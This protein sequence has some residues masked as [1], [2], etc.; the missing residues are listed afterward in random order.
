[1]KYEKT[2]KKPKKYR[3]GQK[4]TNLEKWKA[5]LLPGLRLVG[6]G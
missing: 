2:K 5:G 6:T 1:V 3:K 4:K